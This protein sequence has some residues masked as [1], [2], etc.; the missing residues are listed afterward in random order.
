DGP[1]LQ[2]WR[3][4]LYSIVVGPIL[5]RSPQ[6]VEQV[7]FL[8]RGGRPVDPLVPILVLDQPVDEPPLRLDAHQPL[9]EG[10]RHVEVAIRSRGRELDV[11][12]LG[13][14][15]VSDA[16]YAFRFHGPVECRASS[17]AQVRSANN[18]AGGLL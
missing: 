15:I 6:A 13:L 8:V 14:E 12:R 11:E 4:A 10:G 1:S 17:A 9:I 3:Q 2:G 16:A 18:N 7:G 5:E